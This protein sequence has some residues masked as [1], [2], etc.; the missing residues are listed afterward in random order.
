MT[1]SPCVLRYFF[2]SR[3]GAAGFAGG[4]TTSQNEAHRP[5][6]AQFVGREADMPLPDAQ[7]GRC[8]YQHVPQR[9]D[10]LIAAARPAEA[11]T[12]EVRGDMDESAIDLR[13][14]HIADG[15][16]RSGV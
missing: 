15:A 9:S 10:V 1:R 16:L 6:F 2:T 12:D 3:A 5:Q 4:C 13:D 8:S 11:V 7:A 14:P